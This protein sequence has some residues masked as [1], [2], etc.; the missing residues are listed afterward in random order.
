VAHVRRLTLGLVLAQDDFGQLLNESL[1]GSS[2][3]DVQANGHEV[4]GECVGEHRKDNV[5]GGLDDLLT[6]VVSKLV[7]D[8]LVEDGQNVLDKAFEKGVASSGLSSVFAADHSLKH[9]APSLVEAVEL[10]VQKHLLLIDSQTGVKI[11]N[12]AE[13]TG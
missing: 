12:H 9:A 2:S 7:G 11:L 8:H 3:V 6:Q 1:H 5:V 4:V 13:W 10:K